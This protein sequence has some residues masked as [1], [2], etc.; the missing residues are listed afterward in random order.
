M[1]DANTYKDTL[2]LPKTAFEM[3]ANLTQR[4]PLMVKKW[5]EEGLYRKIRAARAGAEKWVLHDGP[6]YANG[7]IHMGHLINKVLKDMVVKFRTM[8]GYD[9][10]YVPGWDC[11]GLPIESA[12]QKEL[13]PKFRELSKDEV[14][15]RC[16]DY[17]LKFVKLQGD[18]FE[19]LGVFWEINK[20]YLTPDKRYE[21]GILDVLAE[22]VQRELVYR[23][24][25]PVHWCVN[26]RTALAEA[27][28]EYQTKKDSSI[29]VNFELVGFGQGASA[30]WLDAIR[31][32]PFINAGETVRPELMIWTTTPW[33]LPANRAVAV[34]PDHEFKFVRY[35]DSNGRWHD[36]LIAAQQFA[37]VFSDLGPTYETSIRA[38]GRELVEAG[39]HYRHPLDPERVCPVVLA[40]YV[41]LEDGTGLVHTAPGHGKEDY[42]TGIKYGL[43]IYNPVLADGRYDETVPEFLRGKSIWDANKLVIEKLRESGG[44]VSC[45]GI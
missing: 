15:K 36:V 33:T 40:D 45:A 32:S 18:S 29:Y 30:T 22:L 14:R 26:D 8:Q 38:T 2:N 25:K 42:Q 24:K 3:K 27:E 17:A 20:P 11:H 34:H 5:A 21:G 10:P 37:K 9:S 28:L 39:L 31:Q 41:T 6:P 44:A 35:G 4:E 23:Q 13:G 16:H 1:S 19:R 43:E 7:D 12:I